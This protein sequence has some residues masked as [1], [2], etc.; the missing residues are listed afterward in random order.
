MRDILVVVLAVLVLFG[1][2]FMIS[3]SSSEH[4]SAHHMLIG[5]KQTLGDG[6]IYSWVRVNETREV[7]GIGVNVSESAIASLPMGE[8]FYQFSLPIPSKAINTNFTH[9]MFDWNPGGHEP[10]GIY[11]LAHFDVHFYSISEG[12][13]LSIGV[14]DAEHEIDPHSAHLPVGYERFPGGVPQMGAHWYDPNS[15]EFHG[16]EFTET[17]I[18]GSYDG[19]VIF[20]EPMFT[21]A[22]LKSNPRLADSIQLPD[23]VQ[24]I[25][26]PYPTLYSIEHDSSR[27]EYSISIHGFVEH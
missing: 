16:A 25:W 19:N 12:E 26:N 9:V 5:A 15:P 13:R 2:I 21:L 6:Y 1:A 18:Y 23:Q 22:F 17:F 7:M 20:I 24:E 14:D 11:D 10:P 27:G 3:S 4:K 8:P